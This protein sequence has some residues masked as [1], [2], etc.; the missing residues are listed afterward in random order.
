MRP[1]GVPDCGR[2]AWSGGTGSI[3][4]VAGNP[5]EAVKGMGVA[6]D[7]GSHGREDAWRT[8]RRHAGHEVA[9]GE[10]ETRRGGGE[11]VRWLR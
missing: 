2:G 3:G 11:G 8:L 9:P 10:F 5:S 1:I 6:G 7:C 4:E